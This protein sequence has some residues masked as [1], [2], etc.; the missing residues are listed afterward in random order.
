MLWLALRLPSLPLDIFRRAAQSDEAFAVSSGE[1]NR[2]AIIACN[3]R[4]RGKGVQAGMPVPAALALAANLH[5]VAREADAEHAALERIAAWALQFTPVVSLALP[6]NVLL[7]IEGSLHL[8]GGLNG[9]RRQIAD[10]MSALG[11]QA[12]IAIAPTPLA[13]QWF[14]A[15]NVPVRIR[16]ADALRVSLAQ[17]PVSALDLTPAAARLLEDLGIATIADC[18]ALPRSGLARRIGPRVF[19][20]LDRAVGRLPDPRPRYAPP[21]TY[22]ASQPLPAPAQEAEMLLFAA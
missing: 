11:Y 7:E 20:L 15:A 21:K 1:G 12:I 9:L 4:A 3:D 13:A 18:L 6:D 17:L 19:D 16:H 22:S 5:V 10:G 8:F 14:C 2:A